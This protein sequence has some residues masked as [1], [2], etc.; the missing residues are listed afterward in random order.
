MSSGALPPVR[1]LFQRKIAGD[2]ALLGLTALRFRQAGMAA[3]LYAEDTRELDRVLTF[4]PESEVAPTVHLDRRIDLLDPDGREAVARFQRRYAGRVAG[5]VVHDRPSMAT[6]LDATALALEQLGEPARRDHG[7][8]DHDAGWPTVYV[9]FAGGLEPR[10]FIEL[11]EMIKDNPGASVCVDIG[12]IGV[13]QARA[14]ISRRLGERGAP[15]LFDPDLVDALD[16][17]AQAIGTA[18]PAVTTMI[19]E[20]GRIEKSVHLHLHDGHPLTPGVADHFGFLTRVPAPFPY[21]HRYSL[22]QLYGP[23]GLAEILR[24]AQAMRVPPTYTL[25]I[26]QVEG[27]LPLRDAQ[28]MFAH[29]I[30]LTNAERTNYW[31]GVLAENHLLVLSLLQIQAN[32]ACATPPVTAPPL[33]GAAR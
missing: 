32:R 27:R 16:P 25:E 6:R 5:F 19:D 23:V 18:L 33:S 2:D 17:I 14:E 3:E 26:H 8:V 21:Q 15:S 4:V 20:L 10:Q 9:E 7:D 22:P 11:A 29:W 24:H 13:R 28:P 30:D 31:L 12:H 1:G